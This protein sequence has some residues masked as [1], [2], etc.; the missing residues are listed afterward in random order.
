MRKFLYSDGQASVEVDKYG[1]NIHDG[2]NRVYIDCSPFSEKE[3]KRQLKALSILREA[4]D[5]AEKNCIN[6]N[7]LEETI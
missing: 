6:K 5:K 2:Y 1:L 4:I 3:R 7:F